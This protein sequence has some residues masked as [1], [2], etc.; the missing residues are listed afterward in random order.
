MKRGE[1]QEL[2][3]I[4]LFSNCGAGD[5][6]YS[7]AGF[8]FRTMAELVASRLDV[9]LLN[10]PESVGI[11]G[12]LRETWREVV[13]AWRESNG[14][15]CPRLV[16]ACP[17]CQGMSTARSDRGCEDDPEASGKDARNLLVEPI[18]EI[19]RALRPVFLV[20]ENVTAFLSRLVRSPE[21]GQV[22]SA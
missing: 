8:R 7:Q 17:P 12:D 18:A 1:D 10:H 4:S 2:G 20:V 22:V 21:T 5:L 14:S 16:A 15:R 6:G 13:A 3:A 11:V 9:A 19:A